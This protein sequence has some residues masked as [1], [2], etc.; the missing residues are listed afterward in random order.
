MWRDR[1]DPLNLLALVPA[2]RL[3]M[4]PVLA[5]LDQL[6]EDDTRFQRVT[7]DLWRRPPPPRPAGGP[8]RRWR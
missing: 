2:L 1:D 3:A 5:A 7:A 4:A 8:R 6:L